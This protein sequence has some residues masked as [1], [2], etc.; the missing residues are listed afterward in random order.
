MLLTSGLT[1]APVALAHAALKQ[2]PAS[3]GACAATHRAAMRARAPPLRR[4]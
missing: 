2:L 1:W 4:V 3:G